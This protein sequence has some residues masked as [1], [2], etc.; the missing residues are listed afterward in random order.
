VTA[1]APVNLVPEI[2]TD[3]PMPP[4]AGETPVI[5]GAAAAS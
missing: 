2:V 5:V 3:V 1:V 4:I